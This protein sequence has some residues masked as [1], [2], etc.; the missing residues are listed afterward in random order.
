M[1]HIEIKCFPGRSDETKTE[2]ALKIADVIAETLD[3]NSSSVS[4]SIKDI[5]E[6]KWKSEVWDKDIEPQMDLLYKKPEYKY[7]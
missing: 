3:C 1:P 5:S 2:C 7:D 4:V 6:E